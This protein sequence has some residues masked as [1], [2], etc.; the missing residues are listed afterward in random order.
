MYKFR[1]FILPDTPLG[2][3]Y[4]IKIPADMQYVL[5]IHYVN[6]G[7]V[8]ILVQDV[9]RMERI[10]EEDVTTWTTTLTTN[11]L[12]LEVAGDGESAQEFD[13]VLPEAVELLVF[14]GHMHEWGARFEGRLGVGEELES[15]YLVDPWRE[16]FRDAPPVSLY[17]ENPMQ[18]AAG[19]VIQT[20]CTWSNDTGESIVFPQEMC[21]AFGYIAGTQ[22]PVHCEAP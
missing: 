5:Q 22:S 8:P 20:S 4:G 1:S 3:G 14:G 17:F 2:D 16:E 7:D 19:T 6:T 9:A 12:T 21:A 13:C 10:A 11:S 15:L 18:L